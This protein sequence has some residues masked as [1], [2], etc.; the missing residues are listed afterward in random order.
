MFA[1]LSL[2]HKYIPLDLCPIVSQ[3]ADMYLEPYLKYACDHTIK[4]ALKANLALS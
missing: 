4:E 2:Y 1:P 3:L